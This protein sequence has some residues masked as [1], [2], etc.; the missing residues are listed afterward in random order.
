LRANRVAGYTFMST[1]APFQ[2]PEVWPGSYDLIIDA[3]TPAEYA[4]DHIP[5]AVSCPV[6]SN[7]QHSIVGTLY[8]KDPH[9]AYTVGAQ[10]VFRNIADHIRE[11]APRL[12]PTVSILVYCF[13]GGKRS[14]AWGAAL[15]A[16]GL[17]TTVLPGGWKRY[18][19]HVMDEL[20]TRP[21]L[22]Q[23]VVVSGPTGCGKTR[24]LQAL[25]AQDEQ[26]LDLEALGRHRGSL[27]G[28]MPGDAQPTQKTFDTELLAALS[29]LDPSR[30]VWVESEGKKIGDLHVPP[31]LFERTQQA[32]ILRV[33]AP[34]A[35]RVQALC[36]DYPHLAQDPVHC[37]ELL[38]PLKKLVSKEEMARWAELAHA[39]DARGLFERLLIAHY[40]PSY[41]RSLRHHY[42]PQADH[43]LALTSLSAAALAEVAKQLA[44]SDL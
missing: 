41:A 22:Y 39:G 28:L 32:S 12:T 38:A 6:V 44:A 23:F 3:R 11:L 10:F 2:F 18:R 40:D 37:V 21:Q 25:A 8:A 13:R 33:D 9:E 26:V 19:R 27:L 29:K 1:A 17:S 31:A 43:G 20:E 34:M 35:D 15:T 14:Q 7:E 5:G 16:M 4:E 24:L 30:R 42:G 36:E